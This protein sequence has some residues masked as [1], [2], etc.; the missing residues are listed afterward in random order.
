M[1]QVCILAAAATAALA[2]GCGS[3]ENHAVF[4]VTTAET[5]A[6]EMTSVVVKVTR[7]GQPLAVAAGKVAPNLVLQDAA[8]GRYETVYKGKGVYETGGC[9]PVGT[10]TAT[11]EVS[12][13]TGRRL[14]VAPERFEV[15]PGGRPIAVAVR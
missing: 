2:L 6:A 3:E 1:R 5:T 11:L 13:S 12:G 9:I 14:P 8:G 4:Q 10:Y 15:K 7:G